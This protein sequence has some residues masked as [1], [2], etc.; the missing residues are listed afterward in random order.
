[1]LLL[2]PLIPPFPLPK[3]ETRPGRGGVDGPEDPE[4]PSIC[5][6]A[7]GP[8]LNYHR[9]YPA[10]EPSPWVIWTF[11]SDVEISF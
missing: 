10:P 6:G 4:P 7:V 8:N 1:M 5:E 3:I 2:T 9:D 11:S